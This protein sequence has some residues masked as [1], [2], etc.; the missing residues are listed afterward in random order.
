MP[1]QLNTHMTN[2]HNKMKI[3]DYN[4]FFC[5]AD[6]LFHISQM[7]EVLCQ[8]QAELCA[9]GRIILKQGVS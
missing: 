5:R 6:I 7:F 2:T 4:F 9:M 3:G 8:Q 1:Q